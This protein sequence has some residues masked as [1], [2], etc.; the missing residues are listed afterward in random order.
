MVFPE[1]VLGAAVEGE[2]DTYTYNVPRGITET[3][4]VV[5]GD[6]DCDGEVTLNDF[7]LLKAAIKYG[8]EFDQ[9]YEFTAD[10]N[11]DGKVTLADAAKIQAVAQNNSKLSW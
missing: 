5:K 1:G 10:V 8:V 3:M 7:N 6:I 11:G 4:L 2:E 9:E